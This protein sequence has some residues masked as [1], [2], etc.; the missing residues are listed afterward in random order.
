[1][2]T[3]GSGRSISKCRRADGE[4]WRRSWAELADEVAGL[5][6]RPDASLG[7]IPGGPEQWT[8]GYGGLWVAGGEE[9]GRRRLPAA[10]QRSPGAAEQGEARRGLALGVMDGVREG[11]RVRLRRACGDLGVRARA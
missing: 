4:D 9:L 5:E 10:A 3:E 11:A 6:L 7:S 8:Q 2:L 1:M